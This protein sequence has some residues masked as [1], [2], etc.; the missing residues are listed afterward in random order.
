[1]GPDFDA[2]WEALAPRLLMLLGAAQLGAARAALAYLDAVLPEV[3]LPNN[4]AGAVVPSMFAGVASDGRPLSSLLYGAVTTSKVAARAT[5]GQ[6]PPTTAR[7]LEVGGRWLDMTVQTQVSDAGRVATG[8]GI[9]VR[10]AVTGWVRMFNP[11]SCSRCAVLAGRWYRWNAGFRRHPHCDCRHIPAT[12]QMA[13]D[14]TTNPDAYFDSL[15]PTK[16]DEA[17]TK[18]GAEAIRDGADIGQVV[19]ARRGMQTAQFFGQTLAVTTE[20]TTRR[21]AAYRAMQ[22]SGAQLAASTRLPGQRYARLVAPR[23]MPESLY[24]IAKDRG[25][26]IRLLRLNGFIT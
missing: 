8:T 20:G 1:M 18:A 4:P 14:F 6:Q 9:A 7:A 15:G 23:V 22:S 17:F 13:G 5:P 16:Q 11:P 24:A 21:G 12:E 3:G 19:N 25:D 2:A 26:A 10:P